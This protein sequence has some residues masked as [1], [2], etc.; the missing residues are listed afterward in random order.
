[1]DTKEFKVTVGSNWERVH[2]LREELVKRALKVGMIESS[3]EELTDSELERL[4][5]S[6][7]LKE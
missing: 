7:E 1:M 5:I 3:I 2:S 4:V 6:K